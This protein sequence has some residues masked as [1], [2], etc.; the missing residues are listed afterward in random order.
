MARL[1]LVGLFAIALMV[2]PEAMA[3]GK[4]STSGSNS[5][6]G[7]GGG[8][9]QTTS[10]PIEDMQLDFQET[11]SVGVDNNGSPNTIDG[12]DHDVNGV[13]KGD[14]TNAAAAGV[15][16]AVL[17]YNWVEQGTDDRPP[18]GAPEEGDPATR[19][20]VLVSGVHNDG[21]VEGGVTNTVDS[22]KISMIDAFIESVKNSADYRINLGNQQAGAVST[23]GGTTIS[24]TGSN[25]GIGAPNDYKVVYASGQQLA[26]GTVSESPLHMSGQGTGYGVLVVD[27]DDPAQ[28]QVI[29]S[30]QYSWTGLVIVRVKKRITANNKPPLQLTGGGTGNHI[31]GGGLVYM[32]NYSASGTKGNL[33]NEDLY[34]TNGN[35]DLK[36][37]FDALNNIN[38]ESISS[39]QLRSWRVVRPDQ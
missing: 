39:V 13:L 11:N 17:T 26:N 32:Q 7:G 8:G 27:I 36:F 18:A 9:N 24:L 29:F 2:C 23:T 38:V 15:G 33:L 22:N 37:S 31:V 3:E 21:N 16:L 12:R 5:G 10:D 14:Q 19:V 20:G 30:G 28:A 6:G 25:N 1:A 4:G 34:E 35:S